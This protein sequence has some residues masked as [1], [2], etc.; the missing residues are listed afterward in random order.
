M[1]PIW[2]VVLTL[3]IVNTASVFKTFYGTEAARADLARSMSANSSLRALYGPVFGDSI[4]GV[5]AWR[6]MVFAGVLAAIMS[7]LIVV[8]HTR[9]EEE[10]G[11]QELLSSAVVGRRAP[12]SSALLAA[13][14]ANGSVAVLVTLGLVGLGNPVGG[15]LAL[16]LAVAAQGLVFAGIAAIMAQLSE[17]ARMAKGLAGAVLGLAF[18]L[19]AAGDADTTDASSPLVW[20]SPLGWAEHV[21]AFAGERWWVLFL[22]AAFAVVAA[23]GAYLLAGRRDFGAGFLPSRP[24]APG[25]P[26]SLGGASGLAWRL[27]RANLLGWS[28]GFAFAGGIFGAI[29]TGAAD[30]VG[31]NEQTRVILERMGGKQGITDAFL[32]SMT[33]MLGMVAAVYAVGS[34]LRLRGEETTDRAEPILAGSVGRLRWAASH[35]VLAFVG[36]AVVL[37]VGGLATGIGYGFMAGDLVGRLPPVLG[38]AL[39]QVPAVWVL[40]GVAVLLFGAFPKAVSA[41]WTVVGLSLVIGWLGPALQLPQWVMDLSPFGHLP[42]LPGAEVTAAPFLW[43]LLLTA[44]LTTAGLAAFRRRDLGV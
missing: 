35:L 18:L 27:Q 20:V 44:L 8:R 10:T 43:L 23:S 15:S 30:L 25:A 16:A 26:A 12:L 7:L 40:A 6:I 5:T 29:A 38:A 28:V 32:A 17:S 33:G 21:R 9:E 34:V 22:I 19:R 42:K 41:A 3:S 31:D 14:V 4:G 2:V 1:M 37:L 39:A 13:G 36:T 24:G 11:R